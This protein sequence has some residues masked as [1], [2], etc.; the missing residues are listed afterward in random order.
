MKRADILKHV[1][2]LAGTV[3][4]VSDDEMMA[5]SFLRDELDGLTDDEPGVVKAAQ[6]W[7]TNGHLISDVAA[8]W[9]RPTDVVVDYTHGLKKFWTIVQPERFTGHDLDRA[10]GDG[11]DFRSPPERPGSVDVAVM[12]PAYVSLGGR[13]TSTIDNMAHRYG[14]ATTERDPMAQWAVIVEGIRAMHIVLR[15]GGLLWFKCMNYITNGAYYN[16]V[17]E[18]FAEFDNI[19]FDLVDW[20]THVGGTG[21]QPLTNPCGVCGGS[22][23]I[24][25][26]GMMDPIQCRA[27]NG[28]GTVARTQE[29]ARNN[30]SVLLVARKIHAPMDQGTLM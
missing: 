11:H 30:A 2:D 27:C 9:L 8:L 1:L 5:L 16:F 14:M 13:E 26:D 7:P 3:D 24:G 25:A 6:S 20:F 23:W 22:G 17:G 15:P 12:D 10:K 4:D 21:P 28:T 18:A 19:G 29:H